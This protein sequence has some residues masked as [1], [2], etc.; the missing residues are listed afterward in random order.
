MTTNTCNIEL[1]KDAEGREIPLDTGVLYDKDGVG[2]EVD[3]WTYVRP[4]DDIP[5]WYASNNAAHYF[6]GDYYLTPPDTWEKLLE[7]LDRGFSEHHYTLFC[8]ECSYLGK[9]VKEECDE[10]RLFN[11]KKSCTE[12]A[13]KDIA[14]RIH[15][16]RGDDE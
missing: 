3:E 9:N 15:K 8:A 6:A 10:C 4:L 11:P 1:P 5:F 14:D 13:F 16:L 12:M 2:H 7:D